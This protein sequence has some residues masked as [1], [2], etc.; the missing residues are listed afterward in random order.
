VRV[1]ATDGSTISVIG[2]DAIDGSPILDIK[3]YQSLFDEPPVEHGATMISGRAPMPLFGPPDVEKL[4]GK[5]DVKGLIKALGYQ[6]DWRVRRHAAEAL[7]Q[8]GD[9]RAVEPLRA[10]LKDPDKDVRNAATAALHKMSLAK[11]HDAAD[12]RAVEPLVAA[13]SDQNTE[14]SAA[15][16]WGL[17]RIGAPAVEPLIAL[18]S[19]Q[20][21]W[22]RW[23]AATALGQIGDA[24]AVEP[25]SAAVKD[26]EYHVRDAAAEALGQIRDAGAVEPLIAA[27]EDNHQHYVVRQAAAKALGRI[28]DAR[29]VEPLI[30][31]LKARDSRNAAAEALGQIGD[32]RAV[33]P[34]VGA[35]RS[36]SWEAREAAAEALAVL[37][38]SGALGQ[39]DSD[40]LLAERGLITARH[41]DRTSCGDPHTDTGI[42]VDF[43]L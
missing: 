28:G 41:D 11:I 43:P 1:N 29:A 42:G 37:Y 5:R 6:K 20:D 31:A 7:D 39:Q 15:A 38:R 35:L 13:L 24:R 26:T 3:T 4:K 10:A 19:D 2:L 22:V 23:H 16:G 8:L 17:V 25:L 30:A 12:A 21:K 14:V 40:S 27:L 9:A 32:P 36:D 34:L 18:L 33:E